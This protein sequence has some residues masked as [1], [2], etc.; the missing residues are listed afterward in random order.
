[1]WRN[2]ETIQRLQCRDRRRPA[3]ESYERSRHKWICN[4]KRAWPQNCGGETWDS[5]TFQNYVWQGK[6]MHAHVS[7]RRIQY[8]CA[9][10]KKY[11]FFY[12]KYWFLISCARDT[13]LYICR[14]VFGHLTLCILRNNV[15]NN[16][17]SDGL[18]SVIVHLVTIYDGRPYLMT[19]I[20]QEHLHCN[21]WT[22]QTTQPQKECKN[23]HPSSGPNQLFSA[24]GH[25]L[26][27]LSIHITS[28]YI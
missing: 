12:V 8:Y 26:W 14:H 7:M 6:H 27:R 28:I 9:A 4:Y 2:P 3:E 17:R 13:S 18:I 5:E 21:H 25:Y 15:E 16:H 1:M 23:Y 22:Y 10:I 24:W 20:S 19:V 11:C